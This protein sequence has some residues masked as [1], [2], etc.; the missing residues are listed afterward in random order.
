MKA[1]AQRGVALAVAV[2]LFG[3][4]AV[5]PDG[6]VADVRGLAQGRTLVSDPA[7]ARGPSAQTDQAVADLL[8]QAVTE[9]AAVRIALL[10]N[11]GLHGTMAMLGISDA[12]RVQAGRLPNPH[13]SLGR[14]A[15]GDKVVVD[16]SYASDAG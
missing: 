16:S 1:V 11:P 14:F 13:F 15:E 9:E 12:D 6:G 4:A 8:A 5:S 3:C 10:N 2:L 7:L